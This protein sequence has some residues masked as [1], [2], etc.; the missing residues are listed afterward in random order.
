[1][2]RHGQSDASPTEMLAPPSRILV[3]HALG[4]PFPPEIR[5]ELLGNDSIH[6]IMTA[7]FPGSRGRARTVFRVADPQPGH[8][9][10]AP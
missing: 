9:I 6:P 1:M 3:R 4:P 7:L 5:E 10:T 2:Q 8:D